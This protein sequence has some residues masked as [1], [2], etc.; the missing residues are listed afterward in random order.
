MQMRRWSLASP[1]GESKAETE[2]RLDTIIK[3]LGVIYVKGCNKSETITKLAE[4]TLSNK[5]I[6]EIVGVSG[7]HVSQVIYMSKK[8][9]PKDKKRKE[10]AGPGTAT[11]P[12]EQGP[13]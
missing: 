11:V 1:S 4:L 5:E 9:S 3:L 10:E 13:T 12:M 7:A 2:R 8:V 6:S